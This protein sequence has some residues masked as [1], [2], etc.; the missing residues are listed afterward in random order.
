MC[1][2]IRL[3]FAG[4]RVKHRL[5]WSICSM[6]RRWRSWFTHLNKHVPSIR[7]R[8]S[9]LLVQKDPAYVGKDGTTYHVSPEELEML[10]SCL[11][12][13]ERSGLKIPS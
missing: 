7:K 12:E 1:G 11:D 2:L 9:E 8:L 5:L 10:A 4:V 13:F 6:T 3:S